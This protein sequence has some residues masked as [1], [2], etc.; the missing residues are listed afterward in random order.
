MYRVTTTKVLQFYMDNT[1]ANSPGL[2]SRGWGK[3]AVGESVI[4]TR[5]H[6][7]TKRGACNSRC[8][9]QLHVLPWSIYSVYCMLM[10]NCSGQLKLCHN[11]THRYY[12]FSV[13]FGL[14]AAR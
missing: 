1:C 8:L 2:L 9:L 13:L 10:L 6:A 5:L 3:A 4:R 11:G 12:A 14:C 7:L